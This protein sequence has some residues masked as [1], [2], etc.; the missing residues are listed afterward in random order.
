MN[1]LVTG[2]KGLVGRNLVETLKTIRDGKN[3][4]RPDL[5]VGEIFEYD[6]E[7]DVWWGEQMFDSIYKFSRYPRPLIQE[8]I[9]KYLTATVILSKTKSMADPAKM[10]VTII[11]KNFFI[12]NSPLIMI[13]DRNCPPSFCRL[14]P[15]Y[16][17]LCQNNQYF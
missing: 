12:A 6:L 14:Y 17:I 2:A 16:N 9:M 13:L 3:R 7:R 5:S 15:Y 11:R 1:I 10:T 4:T 8:K